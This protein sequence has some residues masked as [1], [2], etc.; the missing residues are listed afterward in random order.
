MNRDDMEKG[1]K[2]LDEMCRVKID[3]EELERKVQALLDCK[4]IFHVPTYIADIVAI[5]ERESIGKWE[6]TV[7]KRVNQVY[8]T[9]QVE[10]KIPT[11]RKVYSKLKRNKHIEKNA[12]AYTGSSD[13]FYVPNKDRQVFCITSKTGGLIFIVDDEKVVSDKGFVKGNALHI[14]RFWNQYNPEEDCYAIDADLEYEDKQALSVD[15]AIKNANF[16]ISYSDRVKG[17]NHPSRPDLDWYKSRKFC[18]SPI[19]QFRGKTV[20]GDGNVSDIGYVLSLC[21]AIAR[22]IKHPDSIHINH[23]FDE[24]KYLCEELKINEIRGDKNV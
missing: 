3:R 21:G 6:E 12:L 7:I 5:Y 19:E 10:A 22:E 14:R 16:L 1:F 24:L 11:I 20:A 15:S 2:S 18:I 8:V 17:N 4:N 9:K 13:V 23:A